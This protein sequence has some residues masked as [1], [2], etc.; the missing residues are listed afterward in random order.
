MQNESISATELARNVASSI[1]R[2]RLS[3]QPLTIT[4]GSQTVAELCPPPKPGLPVKQL[5]HV[6]LNLPKLGDDDAQAMAKDMS[7]V[8][9]HATLPGT[10]WA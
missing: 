3:G 6:L 10:P 2:V 9:Q 5:L 8:R 7:K 1:D 4:K